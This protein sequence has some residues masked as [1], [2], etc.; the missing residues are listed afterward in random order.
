MTTIATEHRCPEHGCWPDD[1]MEL[2]H[3]LDRCPNCGDTMTPD[4]HFA[5]G[6][7]E[8]REEE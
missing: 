6:I 2:L 1:C 7:C 5:P 8:P 4:N 3:W